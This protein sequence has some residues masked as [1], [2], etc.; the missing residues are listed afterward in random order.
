MGRKVKR[1]IL[2]FFRHNFEFVF[3]KGCHQELD[4]IR[5]R[6]WWL[7]ELNVPLLVLQRTKRRRHRGR[8]TPTTTRNGGEAV[9]NADR[10]P[11]RSRVAGVVRRAD[12]ERP[13]VAAVRRVAAA[14]VA[15]ARVAKVGVGPWTV[16][17]ES[18][19]RSIQRNVP[20]AIQRSRE[21]GGVA[22]T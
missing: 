9:R 2:I 20:I 6:L 15:A 3:F 14:R 21:R 8:T 7:R 17:P 19:S 11:D 1:R 22:T 4:R 5:S 13:K 16:Q 10:S 12:A 18:G